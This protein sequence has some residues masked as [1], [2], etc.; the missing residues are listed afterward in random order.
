M[1][2]RL[3]AYKSLALLLSIRYNQAAQSL[4]LHRFESIRMGRQ[5]L[6]GLLDIAL[7]AWCDPPRTARY[8][9]WALDSLCSAYRER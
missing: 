8:R 5:V 3:P 6:V 7:S 1:Y 2:S 9:S 4:Q